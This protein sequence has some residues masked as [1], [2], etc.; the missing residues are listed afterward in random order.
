MNNVKSKPEFHVGDKVCVNFAG[1]K[2]SFVVTEIQP[3]ND[4]SWVY[5]GKGMVWYP[6]ERLDYDLDDKQKDWLLRAERRVDALALAWQ[7]ADGIVEE[8]REMG[9]PPSVVA[10]I[11]HELS[12]ITGL[13]NW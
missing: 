12:D 3:A 5:T 6:E 11:D 4:G 1:S 13:H 10:F 9:M 7:E 2:V 8:A